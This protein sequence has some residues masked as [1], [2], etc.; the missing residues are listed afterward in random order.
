MIIDLILGTQSPRR[1]EIMSY[2]SL[3]FRQIASDFDESEIAF[4]GD[5]A[6]YVS[7]IS[8]AKNKTLHHMYP[9]SMILTADTTVYKDGKIY[10]K[11]IDEED[12]FQMLSI[13]SGSWHSVYTAVTLCSGNQTFSACEE[14]KVFFNNLSPA[15]IKHYLKSISWQDK[16]GSY[17]IQN[18]GGLLINK[19]EGC[20]YNV[21]GLPMNAMHGVFL[22]HGIDLWDYLKA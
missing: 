18:I 15:Q 22:K 10:G 19:I 11:P 12:A 17:T 13:L 14:T 21:T 2:F 8:Q 7:E 4:K 6:Q 9:E 16:A 5:P 20:Y 1:K 3:P